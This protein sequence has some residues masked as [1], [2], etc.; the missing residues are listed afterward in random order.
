MLNKVLFGISL[1]ITTMMVLFAIYLWRTSIGTNKGD[2]GQLTIKSGKVE[3]TADNESNANGKTEQSEKKE[4]ETKPE[5][6]DEEAMDDSEKNDTIPGEIIT[7]NPGV[8]ENLVI[9]ENES[10]VYSWMTDMPWVVDLSNVSVNSDGMRYVVLYYYSDE[11][12]NAE[13]IMSYQTTEDKR[14]IRECINNS[15]YYF[16]YVWDTKEE[17]RASGKELLNDINTSSIIYYNKPLESLMTPVLVYDKEKN[18]ITWDKVE[19]ADYYNVNIV[20]QNHSGIKYTSSSYDTIYDIN[21]DNIEAEPGTTLEIRIA[22]I[23]TNIC[24]VANSDWS[25]PVY[26]TIP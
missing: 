5:S 6:I 2:D 9:V 19:Y 24:R 4:T 15:G 20:T 1:L 12:N 22:A 7:E 23:S 25:E 8:E 11:I 17:I 26:V 18:A 10:S 21:N 3:E 14:D 13:S 16:Y